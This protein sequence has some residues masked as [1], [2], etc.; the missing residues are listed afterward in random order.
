MSYYSYFIFNSFPT[1]GQKI[2]NTTFDYNNFSKLKKIIYLL[3]KLIVP[4]LSKN[5][6]ILDYIIELHDNYYNLNSNNE[7]NNN[8][9][10]NNNDLIPESKEGSDSSYS[11]DDNIMNYITERKN[12]NILALKENFSIIKNNKLFTSFL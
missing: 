6:F 10:N 1:E 8:N 7:S 9:N 4:Y 5:K 3:L 2:F 11:N 12:K